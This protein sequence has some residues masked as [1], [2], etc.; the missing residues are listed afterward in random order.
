MSGDIPYD[1]NALVYEIKQLSDADGG[2][3]Q[4]LS[5]LT[6]LVLERLGR[7]TAQEA[8]QRLYDDWKAL[9]R[10]TVLSGM[11]AGQI[12]S[13]LPMLRF[14]QRVDDQGKVDELRRESAAHGPRNERW[15]AAVTSVDATSGLQRLESADDMEQA[16]AR[17]EGA[18]AAFPDGSPE[19]DALDASHAGIRAHLAQLGGG[20][21]D[22]DSAVEDLE[23]LRSSPAF[24]AVTRL[25][26]EAQLGVFHAHQ[27]VRREDETGLAR[28]IRE[29]EDV[30]ERMPHDAMDRAGLEANLEVARGNLGILQARR[31]GSDGYD[32]TALDAFTDLQETRRQIAMLP[33]E[34]QID[35]LGEV[36]TARLGRALTAANPQAAREA[37]ELLLDTFDLLEPDDERWVR[38]AHVVGSG[39][40]ALA[41]L[42]GV[43]I[44]PGHC[45]D[46]GIAWLSHSIRLAKGPEHPLWGA[47]NMSL[48]R[49]YRRRGDTLP[50]LDPSRGLNHAASRRSGLVAAQAA[51][52]TVL[53][54]SGTAH[55]AESGRLA[56][57]EAREVARWCIA[58]GMYDEAVRALDTGRGLVLHAATV[59]ATVPELLSG[60][61]HTEL[62]DEW[63]KSADGAEA[64]PSSRLRRR[65]LGALGASP[66]RRRLLDAPTSKRIGNALRVMG[67]RALVYLVPRGEGVHGSALVV[68]PDGSVRAVR[69]PGLDVRAPELAGYRAAGAPGRDAGGP[70]EAG[71]GVPGQDGSALAR[72]CDWAGRV[73]MEPLLRELPRGWGR[74]ASV[75]LVPMGELGVVPWHAARLPRSGRYACQEAEISYIPS[76]RLLCEVAER[77][78][79]DVRQALVVG[80]PTRDLRHA[81][82]E[83]DAVRRVFYPGGELLGPGAATP[84]AVK[85]WLGRQRGGVLHLACHGVVEQGG[86]H[87]SYLSL[88]GGRLP[89]EEL[90]E[91]SDRYGGL[92]LVVLA[93]C[94]TNVSGHGFDEAYSL[95]TAFLVAGARSVVGSMWPVPDEATSLLMYMVHHFSAREGMPPG[96]ALRGAQLWMLDPGREAPP[97][98]P[99]DMVARVGRIDADDLV[100]WAGFTHLGW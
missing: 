49:G 60:L 80:D 41:E 69:L 90:T 89:A 95:A 83:A 47:M 1:L 9:P 96:Q 82:E 40:V 65:V 13:I 42:P 8:W 14:Q 15:Q 25:G 35:R 73:V 75:V 99:A 23:K 27:A 32:R 36:G 19:R 4:D 94:R 10:K 74:A 33:G 28:H 43:G 72:L 98:M 51:A 55:G 87:S 29:L 17:L 12:L 84:A 16:L 3:A 20:H 26:L 50:L 37:L 61:G 5:R 78:A 57:E 39:Y 77:P 6:G 71:A 34:G 7:P 76:A 45:R 52:W 11:R 85:D 70:P 44:D 81:G 38:N 64:G 30:L 48:A 21:D 88:A 68:T 58:D 31:A 63:R 53:L 62:V 2:S 59:G 18:R 92:E 93:A 86:R 67:R 100:G 56:G 24:D 22:F 66:H 91:G 79:T 54:Q 97:G 46:Q